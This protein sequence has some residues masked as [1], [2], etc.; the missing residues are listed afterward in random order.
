MADMG[1]GLSRDVMHTAFRIAE[2]GQKH[3]FSSE[4]A[5]RLWF[6]KFRAQHPSLTTRSAQS[7]SHSRAAC[8]NEEVIVDF[9]W[10]TWLY[11]ICPT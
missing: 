8:G 9:I 6:Y 7:L 5:G 1:F 11:T 4:S 3:H 2:S 10:E